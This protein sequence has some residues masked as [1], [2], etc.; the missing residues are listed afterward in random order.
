MHTAYSDR[1]VPENVCLWV[2]EYRSNV[3]MGGG[4]ERCSSGTLPNGG[5]DNS[6]PVALP[7]VQADKNHTK[8]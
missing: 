2:E 6:T 4:I 1:E 5:D 7:N 3:E 8:P